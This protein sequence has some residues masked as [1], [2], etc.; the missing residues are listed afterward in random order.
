MNPITSLNEA[1]DDAL[2]GLPLGAQLL[3]LRG[4]RRFMRDNTGRV[5]ESCR[6]S[7]GS[8]RETLH[9]PCHQGRREVFPTKAEIRA[10]VQTLEEAGLVVKLEDGERLA[11][12][13]PMAGTDAAP[14][15][16][17]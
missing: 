1:E 10:T 4:L 2:Q 11:F 9:V 17:A 12:F 5:G 3:Y 15:G 16:S 6:I 7:W 8:L 14:G 13:L